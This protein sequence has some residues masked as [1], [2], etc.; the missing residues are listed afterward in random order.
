MCI[1]YFSPF[2]D[3]MISRYRNFRH[4][5]VINFSVSSFFGYNISKLP[6]SITLKQIFQ[7][8]SRKSWFFFKS[9][10][11]KYSQNLC[12]RENKYLRSF[13]KTNVHKYSWISQSSSF[14][15]HF[16]WVSILSNILS[17]LNKNKAK[18][19]S[20]TWYRDFE[21]EL[22]LSLKF[23]VLVRKAVTSASL[24]SRWL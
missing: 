21:L 11:Q 24:C 1:R 2:N 6:P 8:F 4:Q 3:V 10:C 13:I 15:S 19:V 16:C 22:P 23:P 20:W 18:T 9:I 5:H 17:H 14:E 12:I 7:K